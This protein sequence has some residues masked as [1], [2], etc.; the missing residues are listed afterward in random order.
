M[1]IIFCSKCGNKLDE[2][3]KFCPVCGEPTGKEG[4]T[5]QEPP[6][7][8]SG[9]YGTPTPQLPR[10][11]KKKGILALSIAAGC[12]AVVLVGV[13][14]MIA[15]GVT[16]KEDSSEEYADAVEYEEETKEEQSED[17]SDEGAESEERDSKVPAVTP[18]K[19]PSFMSFSEEIAAEAMSAKVKEYSVE[20][21]LANVYNRKQLFPNEEDERIKLLAK[22]LFL[23]EPGYNKEFYEAYEYNRYSVYPSFVTVDSMMHTYH[24]YFSYLMKKTERDYLSETLAELSESMLENSVE[25]YEELRGSEWEEAAMRNVAFFSVGAYLQNEKVKIPEEVSGMVSQELQNIMDA[26]GIIESALMNT[27]VD[28]SQFKPRGYYEGDERLEQYF[29]AMMWYGQIGFKQ[30]EE[31]MDR[32]ALLI[33][34][35]LEDEAFNQWEAIYS[36]TSFFAG[37]SDDLTYYEYFPAVEAAYGKDPEAEAL[38]GNTEGWETFRELTARME[39][40]AINSLPVMDDEDP[41]TQATE[42]NKGFRFMGQR[43]TIDAAIFQQLI[44]ENVQENSQGGKR[45]LPDVL[46]VAAALGSDAAYS[47]LEEQGDTDYENYTEQMEVLRKGFENA[48]ETIWSASLYSGWLHTL[49]PLL[50]EKGEGYPAF[51]QSEQWAKKNLESFAGSYT[52]LKHDTVLYAKQVMAEMG[53]GEI[54]D[55]DDRGY[56]EPEVEVWSRFAQLASK[57]MQGLKTY[58]LLSEE[59]ETNLKRLQEMAEQFLTMSQKELKNELLTDEEYELIRNYGGNL[60]HFWLEAFQDEGEDIR[61]GDFPAAIVTDIA[62]DPNGSCLEV[63]TGNP[64]TIY[65]VVPIDGELHICVGA[66]YSFYQFEQPLSERLTDSEWRQIM[67]IAVKEDGTYNFDAPVDAPEW[68]RSYRYEYGY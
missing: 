7:Y 16:K 24:L 55:W 8:G 12:L 10:K 11:P 4:E 54:P 56:V 58:G 17:A 63:G 67:G 35:A 65:V 46:D 43:F 62:T 18:L 27:R 23:V 64:S 42:E 53:G 30:S 29:R 39:A 2:D 68:T 5:Y 57:T 32:S 6:V 1:K 47:I 15:L 52:E 20:K 36:V 51:M 50:E 34:L 14:G 25:Q 38:V 66:V 44:Y 3:V 59:D 48:P 21:D 41:S 49:T 45:M 9:S 19:R 13:I 61:S 37:A 26:S 31:E 33:T 40:P 28:Y 22:N 60:E